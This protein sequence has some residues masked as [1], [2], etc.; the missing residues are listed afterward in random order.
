MTTAMEREHFE[1]WLRRCGYTDN[2]YFTRSCM[3][4]TYATEA[5]HHRWQAWQERATVSAA[6]PEASERELPPLPEPEGIVG[7]YGEWGDADWLG[8]QDAYTAEQMRE[9][10]RAALRAPKV[11]AW[12]PV[13][14]RLPERYEPSVVWQ[15]PARRHT[16][17]WL[18]LGDQWSCGDGVTHWMPLPAA[19]HPLPA[20]A[21]LPEVSSHK[22]QPAKWTP[23]EIA[24]GY[25]GL[26]WVTLDGVY[27]RPT[28]D[29]LRQALVEL[30]D[31]LLAP[32]PQEQQGD[33]LQEARPDELANR[34]SGQR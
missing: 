15:E 23:E 12:I 31:V 33:A 14:E 24:R 6:A 34:R 32:K 25:V 1:A 29:D 9:Y 26:R 19:P 7:Y 10:A 17:G 13:S 4:E 28:E 5:I 16:L 21:P 18:L 22:Q 11:E 30:P 20:L 27:G 3:H 8:S 2:S